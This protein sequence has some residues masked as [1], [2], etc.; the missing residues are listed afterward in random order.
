MPGSLR[1]AGAVVALDTGLTAG[2]DEE[3]AAARFGRDG[4]GQ[5]P[6]NRMWARMIS[7]RRSASSLFVHY[8]AVGAGCHPASTA[9]LTPRLNSSDFANRQ[10]RSG[11]HRFRFSCQRPAMGRLADSPSESS[12]LSIAP[13]GCPVT[14]RPYRSEGTTMRKIVLAVVA[15]LLLAGAVVWAQTTVNTTQPRLPSSPWARSGASNRSMTRSPGPR[16][17]GTSVRTRIARRMGKVRNRPRRN[18][19]Y[20]ILRIPSRAASI[21]P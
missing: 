18:A 5:V 17:M 1:P 12:S 6:L 2:H 11:R 4:L 8:S 21:V 16:Q 19:L 9:C 20:A 14:L 10:H 13:M 7:L 3:T 15:V